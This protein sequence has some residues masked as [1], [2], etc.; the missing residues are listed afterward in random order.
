MFVSSLSLLL[1][2]LH[3][4]PSQS[5]NLPPTK[6]L[7]VLSITF[8]S[9]LQFHFPIISLGNQPFTMNR[10]CIIN[11]M[12]MRFCNLQIMVRVDVSI[13]PSMYVRKIIH[14]RLSL[15]NIH[16]FRGLFR[17]THR[18]LHCISPYELSTIVLLMSYLS[19]SEAH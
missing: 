17:L 1:Q 6:A 7:Y 5:I 15:Q 16:R 9:T 12:I 10:I 8:P 2:Q 19:T 14:R 11:D 3:C 18:L 13:G 4:S